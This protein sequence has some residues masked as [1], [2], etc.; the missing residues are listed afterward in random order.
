M[1]GSR[2]RAH[3]SWWTLTKKPTT[4]LPSTLEAFSSVPY[5]SSIHQLV[6]RIFVL[7]R[8]VS[9]QQPILY[10]R[11]FT[12]TVCALLQHVE[13]WKCSA[14]TIISPN[15]TYVRYVVFGFL[16]S[17]SARA[18][19]P[20]SCALCT[21][22]PA[23]T[24]IATLHYGSSIVPQDKITIF[25]NKIAVARSNGTILN[26]QSS[27]LISGPKNPPVPII[28]LE[29]WYQALAHCDVSRTKVYPQRERCLG[30][31]ECVLRFQTWR[32]TSVRVRVSNF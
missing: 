5:S 13:L 1:H 32:P 25:S 15:L 9:N 24:V 8:R 10:E 31:S 19:F 28:V 26:M 4:E 2:T 3:L 6:L 29:V 20:A 21:I 22:Y 16:S 18:F 14:L 27:T 12:H 30:F 7:G 11:A 23:K 17:T